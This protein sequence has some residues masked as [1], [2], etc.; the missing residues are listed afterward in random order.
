MPLSVYTLTTSLSFGRSM[1]SI[2][3]TSLVNVRTRPASVLEEDDK[4]I[5]R[6]TDIFGRCMA[7]NVFTASDK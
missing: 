5:T 6:N 1:V 7:D 3:W 2:L 4:S